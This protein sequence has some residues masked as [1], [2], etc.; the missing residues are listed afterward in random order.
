MRPFFTCLLYVLAFKGWGCQPQSA[1]IMGIVV[2]SLLVPLYFLTVAALV[3]AEVALAASVIL[4]WMTNY[5]YQ[6]ISLTTILPGI[7]F[8][9]SALLAAVRYHKKGG[10]G[11]LYLSGC[12]INMVFF[13]GMRTCFFCRPLWGMNI[14]SIK[15]PDFSLGSCT[16][17]FA[18]VAVF[19]FFTAMVIF[20]ETLFM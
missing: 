9:V 20:T 4:L 7:L 19:I 8:I 15:K 5:V 6:S 10:E 11:Y 1:I 12:L 3:N 2:G 14:C 13:A 17:C 18:P 16:D